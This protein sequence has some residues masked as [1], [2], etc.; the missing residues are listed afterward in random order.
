M[1]LPEGLLSDLFRITSSS[2]PLPAPSLVRSVALLK[3][4][5]AE[6][7]GIPGRYLAGCALC[8]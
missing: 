7:Q 8:S 6:I 4:P 3:V 1:A 5:A 2:L